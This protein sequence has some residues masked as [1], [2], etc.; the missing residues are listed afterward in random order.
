MDSIEELNGQLSS[1][2]QEAQD[3]IE[4]NTLYLYSL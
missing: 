4:R 2:L 1:W 3:T